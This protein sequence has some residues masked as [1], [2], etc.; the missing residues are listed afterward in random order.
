MRV[1]Y[2]PLLLE[3]FSYVINKFL[4]GHTMTRS[5]MVLDLRDDAPEKPP[6]IRHL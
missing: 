6:C 1:T 2:V 4:H 5:L 3:M